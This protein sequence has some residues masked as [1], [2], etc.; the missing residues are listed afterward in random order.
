MQL[1]VRHNQEASAGK[2]SFTMGLNHLADMVRNKLV[3]FSFLLRKNRPPN[4]AVTAQPGVT[5]I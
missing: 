2:H 5:N 4:E 3:V 1:V